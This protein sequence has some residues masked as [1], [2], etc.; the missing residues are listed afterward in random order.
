[1]QAHSH[2]QNLVIP[3]PTLPAPGGASEFPKT[4]LTRPGK[5]GTQAARATGACSLGRVAGYRGTAGCTGLGL[6]RGEELPP[7]SLPGAP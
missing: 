3:L 7:P 4:S 1:M 6:G 5:E 2:R